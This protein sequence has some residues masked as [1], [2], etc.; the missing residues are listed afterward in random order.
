M[1]DGGAAGDPFNFAQNLES[2]LGKFLRI[3]IEKEPYA[4]P[5]DNPS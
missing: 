1:G 2:L 3:D 5:Q 4:I